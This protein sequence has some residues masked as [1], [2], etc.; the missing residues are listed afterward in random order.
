MMAQFT[1]KIRA[2]DG[3][4]IEV[5]ARTCSQCNGL[6]RLTKPMT[7]KVTQVVSGEG[8][9]AQT[10]RAV[11]GYQCPLCQGMGWHQVATP[12]LPE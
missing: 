9:E 1:Q 11:A 3:N 8:F 10:R 7:Y 4:T 5:Q 6:G 2:A 12:I